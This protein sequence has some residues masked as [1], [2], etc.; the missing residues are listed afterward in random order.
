MSTTETPPSP[1]TP[2]CPA[3]FIVGKRPKSVWMR[4][5]PHDYKMAD[6]RTDGAMDIEVPKCDI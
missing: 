2:Y 3:S 4:Y 1:R 6:A 5:I